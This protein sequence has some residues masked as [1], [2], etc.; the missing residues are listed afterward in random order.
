[1]IDLCLECCASFSREGPEPLCTSYWDARAGKRRFTGKRDALKASQ[2]PGESTR[3]RFHM[4]CIRLKNIVYIFWTLSL[5]VPLQPRTPSSLIS[6]DLLGP[7]T[8]VSG[9]A[10]PQL[11]GPKIQAPSGLWNAFNPRAEP[12]WR[13]NRLQQGVDP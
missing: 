1:M 8:L 6:G 12:L 4:C 7:S 11:E 3:N 2:T 5:H 10:S 13:P 9:P